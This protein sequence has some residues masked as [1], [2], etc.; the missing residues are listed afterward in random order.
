M[1]VEFALSTVFT[2]Y[3]SNAIFGTDGNSP[4]ML[5]YYAYALMEKA[6]QLDPTLLGY[7]MFKNWKNR[8]LGTE[9]AFTCTALLYDIMIIHANEQCKETLHKIIPPA[10]R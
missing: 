1:A 10:W 7:Q 6:H 8:L 9:N 3:S 4:L 2:R 5:R